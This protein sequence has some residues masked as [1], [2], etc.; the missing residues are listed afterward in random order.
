MECIVISNRLNIIDSSGLLVDNLDR[1]FFVVMTQSNING[2]SRGTVS[3]Y[4]QTL[5]VRTY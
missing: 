5:F 3:F 4:S 1:E 2:S